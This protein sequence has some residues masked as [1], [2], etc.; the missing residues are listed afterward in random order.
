MLLEVLFTIGGLQLFLYIVYRYTD[1]NNIIIALLPDS[2]MLWEAGLPM[3]PTKYGRD[4]ASKAPH[5]CLSLET[6]EKKQ[7]W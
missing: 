3:P 2:I 7:E 4:V 1:S 6:T 5:Q